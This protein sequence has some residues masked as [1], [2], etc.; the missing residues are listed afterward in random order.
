MCCNRLD[1]R[2][3]YIVGVGYLPDR[4]VLYSCIGSGICV[5]W[6]WVDVGFLWMELELFI[7]C[8]YKKGHWII[9]FLFVLP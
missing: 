9:I 6:E 4:M 5:L 3:L 7:G 1:I 2:Y 8:P